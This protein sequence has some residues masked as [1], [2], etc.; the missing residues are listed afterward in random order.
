MCTCVCD[1]VKISTQTS[2]YVCIIFV[3]CQCTKME[4]KYTTVIQ[5]N[6]LTRLSVMRQNKRLGVKRRE[7]GYNNSLAC[8]TES[9]PDFLDS[10]CPVQQNQLTWLDVMMRQKAEG[11]R[12]WGRLQQLLSLP[13]WITSYLPNLVTSRTAKAP[14]SAWCNDKTGGRR[15]K[16]ERQ[17][18]RT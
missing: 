7:A 2:M 15:Y 16:G 11:K 6:Q 1:L 8:L 14:N 12:D 13:Q 5:R 18:T 3:G 10:L 9:C 17:A 4:I